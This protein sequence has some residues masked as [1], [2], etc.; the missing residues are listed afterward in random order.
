[1]LAAIETAAQKGA[2]IVD[3][4]SRSAEIHALTVR[5]SGEQKY[6]IPR[7]RVRHDTMAVPLDFVS[8]FRVE[9]KTLIA[10]AA[11]RAPVAGHASLF[12]WKQTPV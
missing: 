3:R 6:R 5:F 9:N 8:L 7:R 4:A 11:L 1:M 10:P 2:A 12:V